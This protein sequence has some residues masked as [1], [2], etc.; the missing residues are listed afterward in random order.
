MPQLQRLPRELIGLIISSLIALYDHDPV[1]Q[2]TCLRHITRHHKAH[3]EQH[4][5]NFWVPKLS[6]EIG[7]YHRSPASAEFQALNQPWNGAYPAA[8]CSSAF[9]SH[10]QTASRST[11][12]P[13]LRCVC[14]LKPSL[15][16]GLQAAASLPTYDQS[17][18]RRNEA[19]DTITF[20]E[21]WGL[22]L[23]DVPQG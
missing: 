13:L 21:I 1:Y 7:D 16:S 14:C 19:A 5:L 6:I 15:R 22:R 12:L 10:S 17:F 20:T 11:F 3:L 8:A 18:T 23:S 2:L 4:F 9:R